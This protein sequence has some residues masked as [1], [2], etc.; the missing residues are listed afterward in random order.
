ME[1]ISWPL[2]EFSVLILHTFPVHD[3]IQD[4]DNGSARLNTEPGVQEQKK[5]KKNF[6]LLD[7]RNFHL[8]RMVFIIGHGEK[9]G[10]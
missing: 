1:W 2:C 8:M 7:W 10:K 9:K 4:T 3:H 6:F 5:F